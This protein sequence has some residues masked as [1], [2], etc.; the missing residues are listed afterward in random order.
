[1]DSGAGS[2]QC[3]DHRA[4]R[5]NDANIKLKSISVNMAGQFEYKCLNTTR[6]CGA[7]NM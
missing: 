2:A 3:L 1:M 5:S 7:E 6:A 4:S